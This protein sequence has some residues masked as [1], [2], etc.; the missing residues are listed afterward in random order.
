M[1]EE[2]WYEELNKGKKAVFVE[3]RSSIQPQ[4]RSQYV[5]S[6]KAGAVSHAEDASFKR[7]GED[8]GALA[9]G[10]DLR[11]GDE[12][13]TDGG[14]R[15][16][17]L[18]SPDSY[19]R[20][21]GDTHIK[22]SDTS[23]DSVRFAL[24][25]GSAI[26]E[27]LEDKEGSSEV[28]VGTPHG[29]C[30]VSGGGIYRFKIDPAGQSEVLVRRGQVRIAGLTVKEGKRVVLDGSSPKVMEFNRD[31]QDSFDVWSKYRADLLTLPGRRQGY[32]KAAYNVNRPWYCGLWFYSTAMNCFT[33]VPGLWDFH[34]PYGGG[35]SIKFINTRMR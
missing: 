8:W 4:I 3:E 5:V 15:A 12:V 29:E 26:I 31:A 1:K 17:I 35:Y 14:S 27:S 21:S 33:F 22:F 25:S 7:G 18:L 11:E 24:S 23:P 32:I 19:L 6:A 16:E 20:L 2:V 13:K 10:Y 28:R 9:V 30:S 34:T